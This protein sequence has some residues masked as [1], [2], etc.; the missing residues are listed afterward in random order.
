MNAIRNVLAVNALTGLMF[1]AVSSSA[2]ADDATGTTYGAGVTLEQVTP[3]ATLLADPDAYNGKTVRVDGVVTSVCEKRGCWMQLADPE[4]G[5][6][7]RIKVEDGVIVFPV[8][9]KGHKASAEGTFE[10]VQLT[11][12][13]MKAHAERAG[14]GAH[15]DCPNKGKE[16]HKE[17]H[18]CAKKHGGSEKPCAHHA[19]AMTDKV[20][21]IRGTGA[22]VYE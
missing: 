9:A 18:D 16:G 10:V 2:M 11:E 14:P 1:L 13:Q 4:S 7:I 21:L 20:Y 22:V 19:K 6:G 8:S 17:G 5:E 12:E 3:I 15:G